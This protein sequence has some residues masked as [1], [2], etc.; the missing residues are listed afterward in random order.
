[1]TITRW[2]CPITGLAMLACLTG[3][4]ANSRI[5]HVCSDAAAGPRTYVFICPDDSSYVVR[6]TDCEA[7]IFRPG[8]GLQLDAVPAGGPLRHAHHDVHLIIDGEN[9]VLSEPGK[10]PSTCRNDRR[11]AV[12]E[13][14]KLDG[15]DFRGVGNEPPWVLEL[16][17]QSRIVLITDYGTNR[18]ERPLPIPISGETFQTTRWDASDLQIE[19]TAEA[20]HDTMSGELFSSRVVVYWQ[21]RAF[22]GCGRPLH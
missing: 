19:I 21:G 16:R 13:H 4:V 12:W 18:V 14:A 9:G 20:C 3:C 7:W 2:T 8:S 5:E 15:V 6:T 10:E 11:R 22:K 17:D 1:M